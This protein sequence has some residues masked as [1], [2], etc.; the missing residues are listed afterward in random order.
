MNFKEAQQNAENFNVEKILKK[1][2]GSLVPLSKDGSC[3]LLNVTK[4]DFQFERDL[5][6]DEIVYFKEWLKEHIQ[7]EF[8][9]HLK[10]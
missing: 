7:S 2:I 9:K 10:Q 4:D 6:D 8:R 1:L 5:S 3:K